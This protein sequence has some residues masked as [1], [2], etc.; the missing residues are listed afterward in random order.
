M[1]LRRAALGEVLGVL[2][3]VADLVELGAALH[4]AALLGRRLLEHGLEDLLEP[5]LGQV[6]PGCFLRS[7]R[8]WLRLKQR[9]ALRGGFGASPGPCAA[10][11]EADDSTETSA[12]VFSTSRR[13]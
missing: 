13:L 12:L 2:A 3:L 8:T 9:S 7:S 4:L 1:L 5:R 10:A 11:A 6:R